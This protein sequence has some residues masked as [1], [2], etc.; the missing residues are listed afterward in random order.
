MMSFLALRWH[1]ACV[2]LSYATRACARLSA[3]PSKCH[4]ARGSVGLFGVLCGGALS[5]IVSQPI[6]LHVSFACGPVNTS[7]CFCGRSLADC[8]LRQCRG[9]E[10]LAQRSMDVLEGRR[11]GQPKP[12][13]SEF[14][15]SGPPQ[16]QL[17]LRRLC[18]HAAA[19]RK[20]LCGVLR[21][22]GAQFFSVVQCHTCEI[23]LSLVG[24]LLCGNGCPLPGRRRRP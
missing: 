1:L 10:V 4:G 5:T 19:W 11:R 3:W 15:R 22:W 7:L 13:P 21:W 23:S 2:L 24:G 8:G 6:L 12:A 9:S 16:A 14:S 20:G 17:P 18:Q